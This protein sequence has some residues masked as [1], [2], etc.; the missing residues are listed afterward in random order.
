MMYIV[1]KLIMYDLDA[2]FIDHRSLDLVIIE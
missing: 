2:A 1:N